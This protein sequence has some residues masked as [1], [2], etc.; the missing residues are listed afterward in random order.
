MNSRN[1]EANLHYPNRINNLSSFEEHLTLAASMS[2]G[3]WLILVDSEVY[4]GDTRNHD[5]ILS[6]VDNIAD[7]TSAARYLYNLNINRNFNTLG[8]NEIS[9][10]EEH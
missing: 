5:A 8:N 6:I 1:S 9:E 7:H 3:L 10:E 4:L 2:R